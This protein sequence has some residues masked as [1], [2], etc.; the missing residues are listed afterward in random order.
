MHDVSCVLLSKSYLKDENGNILKENGREKFE[1]KENPVPIISVEKVWKDEF[2]KANQQGIRPSIRI[3]MS[4][5]N[6]DDEEEVI[7]MEKNYT[8][9]RVDGDN[10]A[11]V[12]LVCARRANNVKQQ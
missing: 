8:I 1:I 2:Y 7:Y 4:S 3:K 6:Y 9:I 11:E 10:E 12:V 5:L